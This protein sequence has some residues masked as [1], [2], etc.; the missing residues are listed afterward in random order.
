MSQK[1]ILFDYREIELIE[2]Q[3]EKNK[4][5]SSDYVRMCCFLDMILSGN[6]QAFCIMSE[7]IKGYL[8]AKV[9]ALS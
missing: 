9:G 8:V 6:R 2:K 1:I 7:R 3:A 4:M 5:S